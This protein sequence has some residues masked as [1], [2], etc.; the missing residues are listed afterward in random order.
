ML[1]KK[2]SEKDIFFYKET[3]YTIQD[4]ILSSLFKRFENLIYLTGGTSLSRFYFNHRLSEDLDI[5][6]VDED[7]RHLSKEIQDIIEKEGFKVYIESSSRY[8]ARMFINLPKR[9]EKL[10]IDVV[11]EVKRIGNPIHTKE[12]YY[13]DNIENIAVNKIVAFEDRAELKDLIDLYFIVKET[14]I[15]IEEILNLADIKRVSIPYEELL[16]INTI[17]LLG[18]VLMLKEV[19]EENINTF[20]NQ[21]KFTLEENIKKKEK[22]AKEKIDEIIK[23]LLWDFPFEDRKLNEDTAIIL[24]RRLKRMSLPT[25][26]AL[27]P[28]VKKYI[29]QKTN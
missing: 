18:S 25:R 17:G 29:S 13:I 14:G 9:Q 27:E 11:N 8:F 10:K 28:I 19:K 15:N 3:L 4:I 2:A 20:L 24:N 21:L 12:G 26:R 16:T 5:F 22:V 6:T 23:S 1:L 7:I